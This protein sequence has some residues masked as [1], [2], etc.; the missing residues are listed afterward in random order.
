MQSR[1]LVSFRFLTAASLAMLAS[2]PVFAAD[3]APAAPAAAVT[4]P[5]FTEEQKT[6][7]KALDGDLSRFE[8]MLAKDDD[9]KH[10]AIVKGHLDG[11]KSRRDAMYAAPFD[12]GKYD[13]LRFEL[14]AE[15]QRLAMWLA[16]PKTPPRPAKK[17]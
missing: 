4:A 1:F 10:A 7:L 16:P 11:F 12:S 9:A 17:N 13:E 8:A 15:Y 3:P 6:Q 14:N 2:N 5:E